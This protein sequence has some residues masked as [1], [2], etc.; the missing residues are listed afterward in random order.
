MKKVIAALAL[1]GLTAC[2]P[3][4]G[5]GADMA[6]IMA[7]KFVKRQLKDEDSF[8]LKRIKATEIGDCRYEVIGTATAANSFGG[9]AELQFYVDIA[10]LEH[11]QVWSAAAVNVFE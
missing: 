5:G 2:S 7:Q 3:E 11:K 8:K 1:L 9:R 4:C 10:H 6:E